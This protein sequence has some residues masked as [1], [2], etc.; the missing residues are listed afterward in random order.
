[1]NSSKGTEIDFSLVVPCY[2]EED[3]LPHFFAAAIPA[4]EQMTSG[5]WRI[6]CVDDGSRD[7]TFELIAQKHLEDP[8]VTGVRLSR[9]FGHQ[10]ALAVGLAYTSGRYVGV[11]DCDLQ[12]RAQRGLRRSRALPEEERRVQRLPAPLR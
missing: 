12:D 7:R 10:P 11:I 1:M 2:N 6:V 9:N 3:A 5:R 4:L 8:R